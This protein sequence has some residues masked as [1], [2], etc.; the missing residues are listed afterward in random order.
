MDEEGQEK[1]RRAG[2]IAKRAL[3]DGLGRIKEGA[4]LL[5]VAE[6]V[7]Q[8]ILDAGALPGFP[9]NISIDTQAAHFT[10]RHNDGGLAFARG[11]L[12]KLD[13]GV[14]VDGYL[15]DNARTVEVGTRNWS[16][17]IQAADE[18]VRVAVEVVRP[19][20]SMEM[21]GAAIERT[22][23]AHGYKPVENLTGHS[24]RPY[25]LHADKSVPNVGKMRGQREPQ[26]VEAGDAYA[27]EPFAT[28]GT[29]RVEGGRPSNIY[30][31][32]KRKKSGVEAAD[33]LLE[34]VYADFQ[35]LPFSERWCH[36]LDARAPV[37]LRRLLRKG[38]LM[39]YPILEEAGGGMVAQSEDTVL[40]TQEGAVPT[41]VL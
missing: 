24:L 9:C 29:G 38:I 2:R 19:G 1:L 33:A 16:R 41:T 3:E 39:G 22:I 35:G 40:V 11:N 21:V 32:V 17:M 6:A 14:H 8:A 12:V 28:D 31:I 27:I 7:E 34:R 30:R 4:R 25:V 15:A 37:H 36:R 18:A 10:P 5:D 23:R 20:V 13:V 26:T